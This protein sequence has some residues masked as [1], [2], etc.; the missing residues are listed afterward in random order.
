MTTRMRRVITAAVFVATFGS[1]THCLFAQVADEVQDNQDIRAEAADRNADAAPLSRALKRYQKM[2]LKGN[3]RGQLKALTAI[4]NSSLEDEATIN[5]LAEFLSAKLPSQIEKQQISTE[6]LLAVETLGGGVQTDAARQGLID[7]SRLALEKV[8]PG[9][10]PGATNDVMDIDVLLHTLLMALRAFEHDDVVQLA[11]SMLDHADYRV[12]ILAIDLLGRQQRKELADRFAVCI[13]STNFAQH[14]AY[15]HAIVDAIVRLDDQT[16]RPLLEAAL[17]RV[18]GLLM[19]IIQNQML[20]QQQATAGRDQPNEL[21]ITNRSLRPKANDQRTAKVYKTELQ[22]ASLTRIPYR[23]PR[24]YGMPIYADKV[25]FVI[26]FSSTMNHPLPSGITRIE[27][28]KTE[29][30]NAISALGP[31]QSFRVIGF[32]SNV[33]SLSPTLVPATQVNKQR[34][35]R[36]LTLLQPKGG[37]NLYGGMVA[38]LRD[39]QQPEMIVLLSDGQPTR[40]ELT[41]PA[42]I[43]RAM[44][45]QNLFRRI[46]ISTVSIGPESDLMIHL[47]RRS[48]G[49]HRRVN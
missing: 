36:Q 23:A 35:I 45:Y 17:P 34:F 48:G 24:F 28:A 1:G 30:A 6:A 21:V 10:A 3:R 14:Y 16:A 19:R 44:D 8:T 4:R 2:L 25:T 26:D 12:Q 33:A 18:D 5:L 31:N 7:W 29:L 9:S 37:T 27:Q 41:N 32:S 42:E 15:R 43:V 49:G 38:A 20:I 40:G 47:A 22:S 39:V 46:M 13:E 11:T